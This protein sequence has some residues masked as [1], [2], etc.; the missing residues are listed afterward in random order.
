[1]LTLVGG[2]LTL[3]SL[4]IEFDVPTR[5]D[6]PSWALFQTQR[7][8]LLRLDR[9]WL[10]IRNAT[11]QRASQHPFVAFFDIK[12]PA[13]T[14]A[15]AM[16]H[17]AVPEHTV[18]IQMD[19]CVARGEASLLR[20]EDLQPVSLTWD[21]GLLVSTERLLVARGGEMANRV[22]GQISI[23]LRHVTAHVRSGLCLISNAEGRP[24]LRTEVQCTDSILL[25]AAEAPLFE[26][27]GVNS[28]QDFEAKVV[29]VG[30]RYFYSGFH[31]FWRI[32]SFTHDPVQ[33]N[34]SDW[35][36]Y[37][38]EAPDKQEEWG[39]VVWKRLPDPSRALHTHTPADY[40]LDDANLENQARVIGAT[41]GTEA[42]LLLADL[43]VTPSSTAVPAPM[44]PATP[45]PLEEE[46]D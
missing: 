19:N 6:P 14:G 25:A 40:A 26:Q 8:H 12:A 21:N 39:S 13:D 10:T 11:E 4:A 27:T 32:A 22:N 29:W 17:A 34:F 24:L 20:C 33:R 5:Y 3:I 18:N 7:T 41:D 28:V 31:T 46:Q 23:N 42:G 37:W 9:C 35:Q 2:Q 36:R 30:N 15:M 44:P 38:R 45:P 16:E 1:M 43:P